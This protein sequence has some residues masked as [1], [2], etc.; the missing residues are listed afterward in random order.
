MKIALYARVS[1]DDKGQD[2]E[3]Q[4][5]ILRSWAA[6]LYPGYEVVEYKDEGIS[7]A[8]SNRPDF[9]RMRM[10]ARQNKFSGI[11]IWALDRFSREGISNTLAYIE[12]LKKHKVFLKSYQESWLDTS[13][14][15]V[16]RLLL[17]IMSWV[18]EFERQRIA[19]RI[20]AGIQRQKN[21][22]QYK[23]G[24]PG[25]T[26]PIE[27]NCDYIE[28]AKK[29]KCKV[30]GTNFFSE[31]V[32]KKKWSAHKRRHEWLDKNNLT[33]KNTPQETIGESDDGGK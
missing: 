8:N 30:C 2:V 25:H 26:E 16:G 33:Y 32:Y 18:A 11:L 5:T 14:E 15:G 17:S 20:K 27:T 7:G 13:D 10:D 1:T 23:G 6:T 4:L 21:I 3:N 29:W 31:S 22:G 9:I 24:R 12:D 28:D 19:S